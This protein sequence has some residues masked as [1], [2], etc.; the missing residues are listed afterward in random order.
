[1]GAVTHSEED[2]LNTRMKRLED[3]LPSLAYIVDGIDAETIF[4]LSVD[5][6]GN[7]RDI[8]CLS[9]V[10]QPKNTIPLLLLLE[11]VGDVGAT[12]A[13][14]VSK[15][16]GSGGELADCDV[17][18]TRRLIDAGRVLDIQVLDHY[19]VER[20]AYISLRSATD[21]WEPVSTR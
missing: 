8:E 6:Q 1:M 17:D 21:L 13:V 9:S 20:G 15:G 18:F 3:V 12:A 10:E 14:Y 5:A 2:A 19:I 4:Q 7:V 16:S 11:R